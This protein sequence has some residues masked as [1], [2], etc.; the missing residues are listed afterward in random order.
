MFRKLLEWGDLGEKPNKGV[1]KHERAAK[2]QRYPNHACARVGSD[3]GSW[4]TFS[5]LSISSS[6]NVNSRN[7]FSNYMM[8]LCHTLTMSFSSP[9]LNPMLVVSS[10]YF[11][12][13]EFYTRK[14]LTKIWCKL[15]YFINV[16]VETLW[17]KS[18]A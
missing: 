8:C 12:I 4:D 6:N 9:F 5:P 1:L 7:V 2:S 16:T 15:L 17:E 11:W 18:D 3:D 10:I 13:K 14:Q